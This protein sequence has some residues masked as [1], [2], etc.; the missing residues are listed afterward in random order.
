MI[1]VG[2]DEAGRGPLAGPVAV[3]VVAVREG[4]DIL[5]AFPGLND[6]KKL[7]E[8]KREL[9]FKILQ[10]EMK[11]GNVSAVVCLSSARMIDDKGIAYAVRHALDR[12][13]RKLLPN[14]EE[15]KVWLDGSLKAPSEYT[16]ET[17]IGGDGLIPSIMLAS[18]AAKVTRDRVM[19]KADAAYPLYGFRSHKG[20]GTKAH[21]EAIREYGMI[22]EHRRSFIHI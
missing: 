11:A 18:V 2:V 7:S 19:L 14:P 3:G 8:K 17:V 9:L 6:S 20:Y 12:G 5:A 13:V 21:M 16:Q 1:L 22:E 15:G 4:Y 10:Q